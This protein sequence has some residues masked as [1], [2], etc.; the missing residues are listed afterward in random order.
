MKATLSL[1]AFTALALGAVP[2]PLTGRDCGNAADTLILE[3][4]L[5]AASPQ[6]ELLPQAPKLSGLTTQGQVTVAGKQVPYLIRHL[7]VSSFPDLPL[8]IADA[9]SRRGC[10]IPQTYEAH[11]PENVIHASLERPG[12]SDWAVLCSVQGTVSLLVFFN[13]EA[14]QASAQPAVLASAP[15]TSRLQFHGADSVLGFNW[16]IDSAS[17]QEVQEAQAGMQHRPS[18]IDHDALADSVVDHRTVYHFYAARAWTLLD[19]AD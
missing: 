19:T 16:G 10:L 7:P 6:S 11:H 14:G 5:A 18:R 17:P 12:S 3:R 15:E 9:L 4:V 8:P 2:W 13:G 1:L